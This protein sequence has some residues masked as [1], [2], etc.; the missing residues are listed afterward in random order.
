M[1]GGGVLSGRGAGR[2]VGGSSAVR[3]EVRC[4][5]GEVGICPV[6]KEGAPM[7]NVPLR[8]ET[9]QEGE[10]STEKEKGACGVGLLCWDHVLDIT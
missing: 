2:L 9:K 1:N 3:G 8:R 4:G 6:S 7:R 10:G 5:E